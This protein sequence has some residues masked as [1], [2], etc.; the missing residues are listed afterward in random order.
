MIE[1]ASDPI[2]HL[3]FINR[4][5]LPGLCYKLKGIVRCKS[6]HFTCAV[7]ENSKSIYF[8]DL[9]D[10]L[11]CFSTIEALFAYYPD[12]WFFGVYA[13]SDVA[14]TQYEQLHE[15]MSFSSHSNSFSSCRDE[16]I[17]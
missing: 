6:H 14:P 7:E 13:F 16:P 5:N 12:G 9:C 15:S 1:F 17:N 2:N 8:N 11:L 3:L 4:I 10:S